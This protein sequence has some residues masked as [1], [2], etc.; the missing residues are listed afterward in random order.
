MCRH[1]CCVYDV[2]LNAHRGYKT[3]S[4]SQG[5]LSKVGSEDGSQVVRLER[6]VFLCMGA[7]C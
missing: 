2:C 7:S 4:G 6:Q 3:T 1:V 5:S